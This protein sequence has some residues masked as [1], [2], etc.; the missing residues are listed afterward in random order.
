RSLPTREDHKTASGQPKHGK[1][2]DAPH[3]GGNTYAGGTGGADTAGLGGVGGPY[4]L[5]K[6]HPVHQ[7]SDE[8]KSSISPE[9][10]EAARKMGQE[11]L[12]KRLEEIRMSASDWQRYKEL[13]NSVSDEIGQLRRVLHTTDSRL[14]ERRWLPSSEG[15]LDENKLVDAL[16]GDR[17]VYR[18]RALQEPKAG[19][20]QVL[21]KHLSIVLDISASMYRF[22][23]VD[24]RLKRMT[25]IAVLLMEAMQGFEER[26]IYEIR[27]HSGDGPSIKLVDFGN[28]PR[29]EKEKYRVV[30]EMCAHAQYCSAGDSTLE[31]IQIATDRLVGAG[32]AD[33]KLVLAFSDANLDRYGIHPKQLDTALNRAADQVYA[34][35]FFIASFDNQAEALR[36][37]IPKGKATVATDLPKLPQLIKNVLATTVDHQ[38]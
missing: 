28:P 31:A 27:G 26:F 29:D 4:R 5:D 2:D 12:R 23:G 25:E 16:A 24:G 36:R 34:H 14:R 30:Q 15:E 11:A 18:R 38:K 6:G 8:V 33:E 17:R 35:V 3:V 19:E 7:V 37:S 10:A 20:P 13:V 1:E 9:A 32:P 21:P 22:N